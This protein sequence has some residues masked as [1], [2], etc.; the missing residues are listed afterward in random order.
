MDN[1][2][3]PFPP[4]FLLIAP[5]LS[6]YVGDETLDDVE[7]FENA[8]KRSLHPASQRPFARSAP[9]TGDPEIDGWLH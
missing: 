5:V 6:Q 4:A 8:P 3:K 1:Q 2:D 7:W 9:L